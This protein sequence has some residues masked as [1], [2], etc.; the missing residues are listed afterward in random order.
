MILQLHGYTT[1]ATHSMHNARAG[2]VIQQKYNIPINNSETKKWKLNN[3]RGVPKNHLMKREVEHS[4][5]A[6]QMVFV[7]CRDSPHFPR[8]AA[9]NVN[10]RRA[11]QATPRGLV[12]CG[13][14]TLAI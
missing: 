14:G 11:L 6:A 13:L 10:S 9:S 3:V 1:L 5:W 8:W 4:L 2:L 7:S 12:G